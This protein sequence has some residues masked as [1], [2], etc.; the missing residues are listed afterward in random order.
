MLDYRRGL[1][2]SNRLL[3][4][5]SEFDVI[6]REIQSRYEEHERMRLSK[7]RRQRDVG[8]GRP[9]KRKVNERFLML[10]SLL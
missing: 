4:C 1:C 10:L 7:I 2:Y 9:F 3:A 8:A 5:I 6:S